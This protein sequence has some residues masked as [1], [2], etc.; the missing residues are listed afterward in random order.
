MT[1]VLESNYM[2]SLNIENC[3]ANVSLVPYVL[4]RYMN[5]RLS[6]QDNLLFENAP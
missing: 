4:I 2:A 3:R 5:L 1:V 6:A